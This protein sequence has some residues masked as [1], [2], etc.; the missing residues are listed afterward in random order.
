MVQRAMVQKG[1]RF[2]KKWMNKGVIN[3]DK[4]K[5]KLLKIISNI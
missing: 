1:S 5:Y 3:E 4:R 2:S